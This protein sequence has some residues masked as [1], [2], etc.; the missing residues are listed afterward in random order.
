MKEEEFLDKVKNSLD[1]RIDT[2]DGETLSRLNRARQTALQQQ[3]LPPHAANKWLLLPASGIAAAL[4]IS[5]IFMFRSEQITDIS[6]NEFDEIEII[7]SK[8]SIELYE[9][10]DFYLWLLEEESGAV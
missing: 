4:L 6:G 7:A 10:L 8:D 3:H 9:Q 2:L 5:S 1:Q